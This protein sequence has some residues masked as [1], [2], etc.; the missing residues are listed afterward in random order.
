MLPKPWI[1]PIVCALALLVSGCAETAEQR[2]IGTWE[3]RAAEPA[4]AGQSAADQWAR[5]A[6]SLASVRLVLRADGTGTRS[7]SL[8]GGSTVEAGRWRVADA[9]GER[10]TLE[11]SA[12]DFQTFERWTIEFV[13]EDR[14]ST[15]L[16]GLGVELV[17][18]RTGQSG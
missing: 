10:A 16:P 8:L 18:L 9:T 11:L 1:T 17:F 5:R 13:D 4:G 7:S 12:D 2:L 15:V 6:L 14:F 3:S